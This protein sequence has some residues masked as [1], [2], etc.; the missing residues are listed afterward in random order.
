MKIFYIVETDGKTW[1]CHSPFSNTV[2]VDDTYKDL[3][4]MTNI[5]LFVEL[6][7]LNDLVLVKENGQSKIYKAFLIN[8]PIF[9]SLHLI[10]NRYGV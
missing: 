5:Q 2:V 4:F 1:K 3:V 8:T 6:P 10:C 7:E 9:V